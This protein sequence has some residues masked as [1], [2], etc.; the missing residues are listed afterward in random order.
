MVAVGTAWSQDPECSFWGLA[1][2]RAR[3]HFILL[4]KLCA[5]GTEL[6]NPPLG[7]RSTRR[8]LCVLARGEKPCGGPMGCMV[9][10][11]SIAVP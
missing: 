3:G 8:A 9:N 2:G 6:H 1:S 11:V 10:G 5:E 7:R 4:V